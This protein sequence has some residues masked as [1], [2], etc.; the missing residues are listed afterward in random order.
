MTI[1]GGVIGQVLNEVVNV[2]LRKWGVQNHDPYRWLSIL[3]EEKGEACRAANEGQW[4]DYEAEMI[5]VAAVAVS[6]V[7]CSR[8]NRNGIP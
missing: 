7:E 2:Q 6:A 4:D 8:R 5:Q 3:G 1:Y